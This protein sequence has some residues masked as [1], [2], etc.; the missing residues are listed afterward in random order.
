MNAPCSIARTAALS[1][2]FMHGTS[3]MCSAPNPAVLSGSRLPL[4]ASRPATVTER[5]LMERARGSLGVSV[6]TSLIRQGGK[7]AD[8][9]FEIR[10][11]DPGVEAY[12]FTFG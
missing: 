7:V 10:F 4:T 8:H 5:M 6:S 11:L 2:G 9:T 3:T 1:T 12:A